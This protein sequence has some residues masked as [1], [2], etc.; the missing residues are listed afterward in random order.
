MF[1]PVGV[2]SS[3]RDGFACDRGVLESLATRKYLFLKSQTIF[4]LEDGFSAFRIDFVAVGFFFLFL[5]RFL[6]SSTHPGGS[7]LGV[8][9]GYYQCCWRHCRPT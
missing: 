5:W 3:G 9:I 1:L 7:R 8:A 2:P 6:Q 4:R